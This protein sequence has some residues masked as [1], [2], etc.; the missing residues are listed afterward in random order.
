[1]PHLGELEAV[2]EP[3]VAFRTDQPGGGAESLEKPAPVEGAFSPEDDGTDAVLLGL[4]SVGVRQFF[5]VAL[6]GRCGGFVVQLCAEDLP[7]C[8]TSVDQPVH[9]HVDTRP[10]VHAPD[11]GHGCGKS[12]GGDQVRLGDVDAVGEFDLV[13]EEIGDGTLVLGG[14]C[15]VGVA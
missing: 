8:G 10:W 11:Q 6:V 12:V 5:G 14:G 4:R 1:M 7:G 15:A 13:D 9:H 2:G 3:A